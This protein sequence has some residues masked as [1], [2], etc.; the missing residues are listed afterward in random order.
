M[1]LVVAGTA[2]L[3]WSALPVR[4]R[5]RIIIMV[6]LILYFL[7]RLSACEGRNERDWGGVPPDF[8]YSEVN[9]GGCEDFQSCFCRIVGKGQRSSTAVAL[10]SSSCYQ[11][12]L[13]SPFM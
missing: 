4:A 13:S 2:A 7:S 12:V 5:V 1:V 3:L 8:R 10:L 9:V 6:R 11:P